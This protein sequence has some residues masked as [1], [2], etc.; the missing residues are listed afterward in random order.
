[1]V[2]DY[3]V[4]HGEIDLLIVHHTGSCQIREI[5]ADWLQFVD[6][7]LQICRFQFFLEVLSASIFSMRGIQIGGSD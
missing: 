2:S 6:R 7:N 4:V 5:G 1:V 3:W